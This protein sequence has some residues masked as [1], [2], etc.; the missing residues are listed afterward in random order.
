MLS[1]LAPYAI[2][3]LLAL[4]FSLLV[5]L[6]ITKLDR[7]KAYQEQVDKHFVHTAKKPSTKLEQWVIQ[8]PFLSRDILRLYSLW[9]FIIVPIGLILVFSSISMLTGLFGILFYYFMA[10][11]F[12]LTLRLYQSQKKKHFMNQF[13]QVIDAM[14]HDLEA[15]RPIIASIKNISLHFSGSV[16]QLFK[17]IY[18]HTELGL[19][20]PNALYNA[21]EFIDIREFSFFTLIISVHYK[22]GSDPA[23]VLSSLIEMTH[24]EQLIKKKIS[25]LA[26]D[27]RISA[28]VLSLLPI[29]V[30]ILLFFFGP[31]INNQGETMV[32][33]LFRERAGQYTLLYAG[34]SYLIGITLLFK[35]SRIKV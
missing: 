1:T 18:H 12:Y 5:V 4:I 32:M 24:Q 35:I 20:L 11:L 21:A 28:I 33:Y 16:G 15:G 14:I 8:L 13:P 30:L 23:K 3:Y 9:I 25:S 10:V 17:N 6:I 7:K 26:S 29:A 27:G 19:S 22:T 34:L 31:R 2:V